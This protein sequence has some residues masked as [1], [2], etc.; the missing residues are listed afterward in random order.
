MISQAS[1]DYRMKQ[2]ILSAFDISNVLSDRFSLLNQH[3]QFGWL[4]LKLL[5]WQSAFD[6]SK[7]HNILPW[8]FGFGFCHFLLKSSVLA[9]YS[10]VHCWCC[11]D[12]RPATWLNVMPLAIQIHLCQGRKAIGMTSLSLKP[13]IL[14]RAVFSAT[15]VLHVI[16][17]V[18][19]SGGKLLN[20]CCI[21]ISRTSGR[22]CVVLVC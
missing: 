7:A 10:L 8:L 22:V 6:C 19:L 14:P 20:A 11:F 12:F 18:P 2:A 3:V 15:L 9:E 21:Q 4:N 16:E 1:F 13:A 17:V 5:V